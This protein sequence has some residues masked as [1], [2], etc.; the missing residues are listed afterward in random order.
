MTE[1]STL[2]RP[3]SKAAFEYSLEHNSL[4]DWQKNLSLLSEMIQND[5][6]RDFIVKPNVTPSLLVDTILKIFDSDLPN[7]FSNF[8]DLLCQNKRLPQIKDQFET[9]KANQEA[10]LEIT[11][12]VTEELTDDQLKKLTEALATNLKRQINI[13]I[14]LNKDLIGG[15]V[16]QAGD[17]VIDNSV[18]G[19]LNKLADSLNT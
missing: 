7:G 11:V 14:V 19:K 15:A 6:I 18:R 1:L 2:A 12:S 10:I 4:E 17:M 13:Q 9:H 3:Y 16:I 8:L 5:R